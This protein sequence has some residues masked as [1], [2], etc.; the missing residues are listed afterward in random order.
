MTM[1]IQIAGSRSSTE[2]RRLRSGSRVVSLSLLILEQ[3]Q[4]ATLVCKAG[5]LLS[6]RLQTFG[7]VA[8]GTVKKVIEINPYLLGTLAG[9]AG[10]YTK[11]VGYGCMF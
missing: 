6:C 9:G 5:L 4:E 7:I 10:T 2:R 8:S 1:Q 11:L 3:Q